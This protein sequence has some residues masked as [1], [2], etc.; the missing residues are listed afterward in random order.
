MKFLSRFRQEY[1]LLSS[2]I[3]EIQL[4]RLLSKYRVDFNES[5][6][7]T[8]T[9][10]PFFYFPMFLKQIHHKP[11]WHVD[12][13]WLESATANTKEIAK[14]FFSEF[15]NQCRTDLG[16]EALGHPQKF[17]HRPLFVKLNPTATLV[18]SRF[19]LLNWQSHSPFPEE[20][21]EMIAVWWNFKNDRL[22]TQAIPKQSVSAFDIFLDL[23]EEL[24]LERNLPVEQVVNFHHK[25]Q[26]VLNQRIQH[27]VQSDRFLSSAVQT[28]LIWMPLQ[29]KPQL[30]LD[31]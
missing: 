25:N 30:D 27:L 3:D 20:A 17:S 24:S 22:E 1:P 13:A 18:S 9:S 29:L 15:Q 12:L 26:T 2:Q 21:R 4:V 10:S 5:S 8:K 23:Q 28:N 7:L 14:E 31:C 11:E 6:C 19:A 16:T